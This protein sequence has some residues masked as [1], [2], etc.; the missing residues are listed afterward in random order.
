MRTIE[1][2]LESR[3]DTKFLRWSLS[4][5][6]FVHFLA[7]LL[8]ERN[9]DTLKA[10]ASLV[11][12]RE[13]KMLE[14]VHGARVVEAARIPEIFSLKGDGILSGG[15]ETIGI[16]TADCL[17][18]LLV[19][20]TKVVLL[21]VGWRGMVAGIVEK[22]ISLLEYS[23]YIKA[24]LG[25]CIRGCC[26]Q[27]DEPFLQKVKASYPHLDGAWSRENNSLRFDIPKAVEEILRHNGVGEVLDCG[28][29]TCCDT[30]FPSYR[31]DGERAGRMLTLAWRER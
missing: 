14:Q 7:P 1:L 16:L 21:H 12:E 9:P 28:F 5:V 26:Y 20:D 15:G 27:V 10:M 23:T 13:L 2:A 24:L 8:F 4:G 11:T 3:G 25:P 19:G 30:R 17:P 22:G 6:I 31:R 18:L 29:C